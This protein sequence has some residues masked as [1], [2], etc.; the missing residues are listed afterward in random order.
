[1]ELLKNVSSI[2]IPSNKVSYNK[3]SSVLSIQVLDFMFVGIYSKSARISKVLDDLYASLGD[4]QLERTNIYF[5]DFV[6]G[7]RISENEKLRRLK[8]SKGEK[9][10]KKEEKVEKKEEKAEKKQKKV[11]DKRKSV[12]RDEIELYDMEKEAEP[13]EDKIGKVATVA[14]DADY[15]AAKFKEE[16]E[17]LFDDLEEEAM[18]EKEEAPKA[19]RRAN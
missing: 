16:E 18:M 10:Q 4:V 8:I 2:E 7:V 6:T 3:K 11:M 19:K 12:K 13:F 15:G 17:I 9:I 5:I 14:E 1:M